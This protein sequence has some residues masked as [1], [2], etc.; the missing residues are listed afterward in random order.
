MT[1]FA[2]F[3]AQLGEP[4][5]GPITT[6]MAPAE[7]L[8]ETMPYSPDLH[9]IPPKLAEGGVAAFRAKKAATAASKPSSMSSGGLSFADWKQSIDAAAEKWAEVKKPKKGGKK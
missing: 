4:K 6:A 7:A 8:Q 2:A 5:R 9:I 1:A 3:M